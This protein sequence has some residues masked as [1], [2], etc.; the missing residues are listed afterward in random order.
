MANISEW[1]NTTTKVDL[2]KR[3]LAYFIVDFGNYF[4][5]IS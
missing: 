3:F 2:Q 1:N 4:N 5:N